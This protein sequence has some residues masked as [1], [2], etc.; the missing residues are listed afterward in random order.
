MNTKSDYWEIHAV[1]HVVDKVVFDKPVSR[2]Q[3]IEMYEREDFVD[4][5]DSYQDKLDK[6][7]KA[8]P[9]K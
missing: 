9:I 8:E 3:A 4:I 7:T 2:K 1:M 6:V 5:V